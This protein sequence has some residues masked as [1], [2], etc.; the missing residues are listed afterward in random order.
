M[1]RLKQVLVMMDDFTG[2][3]LQRQQF[4]GAEIPLVIGRS[5]SGQ[6]GFVEIVHGGSPERNG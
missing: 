5:G 3:L 6:D 4:V 1:H 2:R